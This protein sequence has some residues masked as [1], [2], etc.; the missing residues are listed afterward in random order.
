MIK[1]KVE[2]YK[3]KKKELIKLIN[4]TPEAVVKENSFFKTDAVLESNVPRYYMGLLFKDIL[5]GA[6]GRFTG[7][8]GHK[9]SGVR[10]AYKAR[11][12]KDSFMEWHVSSDQGQYE[13]FF[14]VET[15]GIEINY[16]NNSTFENEKIVLNE[17]EI[18]F[19]S[20]HCPRA[21]EKVKNPSKLIIFYLDIYGYS[22][23]V[24]SLN[25]VY[26]K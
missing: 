24:S 25:Y 19:I 14:G 6:I 4:K 1:L 11:F 16:H 12:N 20:T 21:I 26:Q 2:D 9:E 15:K 17:G 13:C 5:R 3:N 10:R 23:S 18:I 7:G 22:P 8:M